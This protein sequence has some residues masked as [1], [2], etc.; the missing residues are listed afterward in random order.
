MA[1]SDE[2]TALVSSSSESDASGMNN[3]K[4]QRGMPINGGAPPVYG[5]HLMGEGIGAETS[6]AAPSGLENDDINGSMIDD[7]AIHMVEVEDEGNEAI[8]SSEFRVFLNTLRVNVGS[9]LLTLPF[10]FALGGLVAGPIMMLV[11]GVIAVYCCF[12]LIGCRN[13]LRSDGIATFGQ[14]GRYCMGYFGRVVVDI[15]LILTQFGFATAY[16]IFTATNGVNISKQLLGWSV[17]FW[18]FVFAMLPILVAVCWVRNMKTLALISGFSNI[19]YLS[20]LF[21]ILAFDLVAIW[22]TRGSHVTE[23]PLVQ[24]KTMPLFLGVAVYCFEG[25]G[26]VLPLENSM[27]RPQNFK[28]VFTSTMTLV[29][30]L[31]VT[32]GMS[33]YIAYGHNTAGVITLNLPPSIFVYAVT[34]MLCLSLILTYPAQMYPVFEICENYIF[35]ERD[36]NATFNPY[37][38]YALSS[39]GRALI[40]LL[41][42]VLAS[43]IP[44]FSVITSLI[45]SAGSTSLAFILPVI[46]H[47]IIFRKEMDWPLVV[48]HGLILIFGVGVTVLGTT[49]SLI[50]AINVFCVTLGLNSPSYGWLDK[51]V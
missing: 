43:T 51:L 32:F 15:T 24:W 47:Y 7:K 29:Y 21:I 41:S 38:R 18:V 14:I 30:M 16:V 12:L 22:H 11:I 10:G 31:L 27:A 6:D 8:K 33:G 23:L 50:Q 40:V 28:L 26:L 45:G 49:F 25:I 13:K 3:R 46:F 5:S 42:L 17:P 39:L 34:I 36:Y 9:G 35:N 19:I 48:L 44:S 1:P 20:A 2:K 37:A 4:G